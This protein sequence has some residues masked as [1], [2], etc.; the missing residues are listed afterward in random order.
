MVPQG[1]HVHAELCACAHVASG[2]ETQSAERESMRNPDALPDYRAMAAGA[3]PP[4]HFGPSKRGW[5]KLDALDSSPE[6][7]ED[8]LIGVLEDFVYQLL[9]KMPEPR[10]RAH[11]L[12]ETHCKSEQTASCHRNNLH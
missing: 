7:E 9:V 11:G 2:S 3:E 5:G 10:L 6:P 1:F 4:R 12:M 8:V